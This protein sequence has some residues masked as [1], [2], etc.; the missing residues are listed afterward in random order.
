MQGPIKVIGLGLPG[1][2]QF[3]EREIAAGQN[4]G[5]F[6]LHLGNMRP[7]DYTLAFLGQAQVPFKKDAAAQ[8][9]NTLVAIPCRPLTVTVTAKAK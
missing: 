3:S 1:G 2:F 4:E 9:A 5:S 6:E 8:P 7:G